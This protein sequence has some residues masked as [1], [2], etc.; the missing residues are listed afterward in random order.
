MVVVAA[1]EFLVE[2][3]VATSDEVEE[4]LVSVLPLGMGSGKF[5]NLEM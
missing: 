2:V 3:S 4:V 5:V 1:L